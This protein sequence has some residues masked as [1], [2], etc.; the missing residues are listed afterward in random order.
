MDILIISLGKF[1]SSLPFKD[2]FNFYKN[3]ISLNLNL[4]ELKTFNFEKEKK[5]N[6]EKTEINKYLKKGD[7]IVTLDKGGRNLSSI[8]FSKFIGLKMKNRVKRIC[9]LIGSEI[10]IDDSF[11]KVENVLS[12]GRQTWPHLIV[13][14]MLVE[15]IYRSLEIMKG[16]SY[17]K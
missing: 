9:F 8:E 4:V 16:T 7:C 12:L 3:R 10:G 1:K 13:R 5:L 17:H 14:I 15:Q 11:K 2:I 6:L